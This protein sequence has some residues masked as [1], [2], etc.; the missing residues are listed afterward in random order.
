MAHRPKW[1]AAG[2]ASPLPRT[3]GHP[4][5]GA[6]GQ[7]GQALRGA[8][9]LASGRGSSFGSGSG[10]SS[11]RLGLLR[12]RPCGGPRI[13]PEAAPA[14]LLGHAGL[15]LLGGLVCSHPARRRERNIEGRGPSFA[16]VGRPNAAQAQAQC[17]AVPATPLRLPDGG[18]GRGLRSACSCPCPAARRHSPCYCAALINA[19]LGEPIRLTCMPHKI[20]FCVLN[21][22]SWPSSGGSTSIVLAMGQRVEEDTLPLLLLKQLLESAYVSPRSLTFVHEIGDNVSGGV[23][24]VG[25]IGA[26]GR[27]CMC[28]RAACLLPRRL[29]AAALTALPPRGAYACAGHPNHRAGVDGRGGGAEGRRGKPQVSLAHAASYLPAAQHTSPLLPAPCIL[30][31]ANRPSRTART[32]LLRRTSRC[33]PLPCRPKCS[34]HCITGG[35]WNMSCLSALQ[36]AAACLGK[37]CCACS[38]C[39]PGCLCPRRHLVPVLGMGC[40]KWDT[41]ED[42]CSS[43]FAVEEYAGRCGLRVRACTRDQSWGRTLRSDSSRVARTQMA[44]RTHHTPGNH[45]PTQASRPCPQHAPHCAA[46]QAP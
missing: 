44:G 25:A 27:M 35:A 4:H 28:G 9:D 41:W 39:V 38:A 17:G 42:V 3:A 14:Q 36:P 22:S 26:I 8:R 24:A 43:V 33:G 11:G 6:D 32:P 12:V 16:G 37:G 45:G 46:T 18:G 2:G 29:S 21:Q 34:S 1:W 40:Y 31:P 19:V 15:L 10:C 20:T 30:L 5:A 13:G 7:D 23:H